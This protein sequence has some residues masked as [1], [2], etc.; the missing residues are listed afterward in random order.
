MRPLLPLLVAALVAVTGLSAC[1][2]AGG[3]PTAT[4]SGPSR[5]PPPD[6]P[7]V[8]GQTDKPI[9]PFDTVEVSVFKVDDLTRTV[10]VDAQGNIGLPLIGSVPASGKTPHELETEIAGLLGA[11]YL[12]SPQVTVV[13]KDSPGQR[14][15]VEGAVRKPGLFPV[16][17]R[18]TLLQ[19]VA[20]SEGLTDTAKADDII[21]FR[22]VNKQR[23]AAAFDLNT[24]R[25]GKS[26][27]PEVYGG[28]VIVVGE[29]GAKAAVRNFGSAVPIMGVFMPFL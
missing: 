11:K 8:A 13:V 9:A 23:M 3:K 27:D 6:P 7:T 26:P 14:V 29:S 1:T 16:A 21:V 15:T 25:N 18:T 17:A 10:E 2:T 4:A 28:D 19:A 20:L 24:I 22:T 12:Q 5:L